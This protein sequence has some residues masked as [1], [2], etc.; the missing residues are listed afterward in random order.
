M[1]DTITSER[2]YQAILHGAASIRPGAKTLTGST[3]FR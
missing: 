3:S 1:T 2:L